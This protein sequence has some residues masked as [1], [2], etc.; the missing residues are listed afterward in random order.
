MSETKIIYRTD[1]S[2]WLCQLSK[3]LS[4]A[5]SE[6]TTYISSTRTEAIHA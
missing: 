5:I 3:Y 6:A 2:W 4:N 1:S